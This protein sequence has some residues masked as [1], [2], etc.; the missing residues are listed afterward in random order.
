MHCDPEQSQNGV[1][2]VPY[3]MYKSKPLCKIRDH[4]A[5]TIIFVHQI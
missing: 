1:F 2:F 4:F 5:R 3:L